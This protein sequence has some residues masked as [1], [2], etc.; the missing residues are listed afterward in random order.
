MKPLV[1]RSCKE[2]VLPTLARLCC[3]NAGAEI[4]AQK[5]E[6]LYFEIFALKTPAALILKQESLSLGAELALP[7]E[8]I[9]GKIE[10]VDALLIVS[11]R[12]LPVLLQ[13]IENQ[14]FGL[15][16]LADTLRTHCT[17]AAQK[18]TAPKIM[19][20]I[21]LTPDSFYAQSRTRGREAIEKIVAMIRDGADII[22]IG[23]ASSRPGSGWID[24]SEERA[25]VCDVFAEIRAQNLA[26]E[27][28]FSIDSYTPEIVALAL[29]SGFSIIN[30]INGMRDPQ[31]R[32]L[33]AQ[34]GAT[35]VLMHIVGSPKTMQQNPHYAH[36][37][38]EV[39]SFFEQQI[40]LLREEGFGGAIIL[41]VGI[42][43][44]KRVQ[45]NLELIAGL[46]HFAHHRMPLLVG[47]SRKSLIGALCDDEPAQ[48]RL[49]GTLALHLCAAR[50]GAGI[51]RCHD[52]KEHKQAFAIERALGG[53]A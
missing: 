29:D 3:E 1:S 40:A 35:V 43:F 18:P 38:C 31:M 15:R 25:R 37:L 11:L 21:N 28:I 17:A 8:A 27:A 10:H 16:A 32:A 39:D 41:D 42:G 36:V 34:S 6:I 50:K 52:V 46:A 4:M 9:L 12:I 22:D 14:P 24:P 33:A 30:D 5:A 7:K 19:G 23:A 49:A 51:I 13:K 45:D 26:K 53:I 47:A 48:S 44:G 2:R 20:V